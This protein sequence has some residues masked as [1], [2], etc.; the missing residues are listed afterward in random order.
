MQP[1]DR[2]LT[3]KETSDLVR[4]PVETLRHWRK[5]GKGPVGFKVGRRVC[6]RESDVLTW[7]DD[8]YRSQTG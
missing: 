5:V 2:L 7:L 1:E 6:Y 4:T 3:L 8:Q